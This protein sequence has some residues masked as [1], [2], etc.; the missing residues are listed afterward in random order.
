MIHRIISFV[1]LILFFS[2]ILHAQNET[3]II[4]GLPDT[5][6]L[7]GAVYHLDFAYSSG[8]SYQPDTIKLF[9]KGSLLTFIAVPKTS[10]S[11]LSENVTTMEHNGSG[12]S[13]DNG[14]GI[15]NDMGYYLENN[16]DG[17]FQLNDWTKSLSGEVISSESFGDQNPYEF[18]VLT[19]AQ[20]SFFDSNM[21][22]L[23][24]ETQVFINGL[25][26]RESEFSIDTSGMGIILNSGLNIGDFLII[27]ID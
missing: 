10:V 25:R 12:Y 20:D 26:I 14:F 6:T 2:S 5:I 21:N 3:H 7:D 15:T 11:S 1:L 4:D 13:L 24:G 19:A 22:A 18:E 27:D 17:T 9:Y 16:G 8:N 23:I